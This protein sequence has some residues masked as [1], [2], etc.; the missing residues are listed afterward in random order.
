MDL[1]AAVGPVAAGDTA[2][3]RRRLQNCRLLNPLG[4][5]L[6]ARRRDWPA[7]HLRLSGVQEI[8]A[9]AALCPTAGQEAA[10]ALRQILSEMASTIDG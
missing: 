9:A 5:T 6:L 4:A 1:A 10:R 7:L 3:E 2:G 8:S